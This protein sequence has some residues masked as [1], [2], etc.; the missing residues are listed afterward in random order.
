M[1]GRT[2]LALAAVVLAIAGLTFDTH[3]SSDSELLVVRLSGGDDRPKFSF[4]EEE[5]RALP[6]VKVATATEFTDGVV[7]FEGPLARDVLAAADLGPAEL[8]RLVAA[9]DYSIEVPV[10]D[11]QN[12]DVIMAL[13]ADGNK[14]SRRDKGPIWVIYPLDD[15]TELQDPSYTIRLVWQLTTVELR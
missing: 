1:K 14:L 15:H 2:F 11:F 7:E 5:L 3:A 6:Q 10:T 13:E 4:T 12:Y 8:A 9:N